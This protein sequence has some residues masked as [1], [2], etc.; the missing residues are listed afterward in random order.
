MMTTVWL[1][2]W[3][4]DEDGNDVVFPFSSREVAEDYRTRFLKNP[5]QTWITE[6][7]FHSDAETLH[8]MMWDGG[9]RGRGRIQRLIITIMLAFL[10]LD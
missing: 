7:T 5:E 8:E 9:C 4:N 6:E 3:K 1:L 2:W 10:H